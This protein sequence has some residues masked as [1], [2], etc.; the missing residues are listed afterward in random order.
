M[1]ERIIGRY[2]RNWAWETQADVFFKNGRSVS[3]HAQTSKHGHLNW[4]ILDGVHR[5]PVEFKRLGITQ[6]SFSTPASWKP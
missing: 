3:C 4:I 6:I 5:Y 1:S 2:R